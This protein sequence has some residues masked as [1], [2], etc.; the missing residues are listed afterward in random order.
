MAEIICSGGEVVLIDDEDYPVISRHSWVATNADDGANPHKPSYA[1]TT[2]NTWEGKKKTVMMHNMILGFG[3]Q[4]D[5]RNQN[6]LDNRKENLRDA[7]YQQN[8]WNK[9]KTRKCRHGEPKSK[10]KGVTPYKSKY[11]GDGWQVIVKLTGKGVKP[12][13]FVR[14]KPFKTEVEAAIAYNTEIVKHRGEYAWLN[15]IPELACTQNSDIEVQGTICKMLDKRG[16]SYEK[17]KLPTKT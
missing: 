13:K 6:T 12:A 16:L 11:F 9:G 1:L 15:P 10:Y 8:G 3:T 5:H 4:I 2:L 14:L 17:V 7:T